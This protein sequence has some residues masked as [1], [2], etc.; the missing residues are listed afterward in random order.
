MLTEPELVIPKLAARLHMDVVDTVINAV[1]SRLPDI[2]GSVQSQKTANAEAEDEF[3]KAWPQLKDPKYQSVVWNAVAS[4]RGLNPQAKRAE[5]VRAAGLSA[6]LHLRLPLPASLMQFE[7]PAA[8]V[9]RPFTP[10]APGAGT[11]PAGPS[12]PIN[13]FVAMSE[14]LLADDRGG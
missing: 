9:A 12:G 7:S 5:V 1:F 3:F 8:P 11:M 14:E 10:A 6:M 4:Y 2:V 13:P